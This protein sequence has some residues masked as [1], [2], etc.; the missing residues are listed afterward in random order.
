[1]TRRFHSIAAEKK[2][3][4]T[5]EKDAM[6]LIKFRQELEGWPF[7]VIPI[8]PRFLFGDEQ[9]FA[10]VVTQ[11]INEFKYEIEHE[12]RDSMRPKKNN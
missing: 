4:L 6:R 7:Y 1:M 8:T 3:I 10:G 2:L 5:T 9:R 11:F 12:M